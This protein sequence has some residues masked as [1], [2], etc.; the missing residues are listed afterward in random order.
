LEAVSVLRLP[1]LGDRFS[2]QGVGGAVTTGFLCQAGV[3]L[4]EMQLSLREILACEAVMVG[5]QNQM[6]LGRDILNL[7]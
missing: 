2:V 1:F 3:Q 7:S 4:G 5:G 6:I